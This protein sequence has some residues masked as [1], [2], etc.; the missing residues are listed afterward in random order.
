MTGHIRMGTWLDSL[1][2]HPSD[3]NVWASKNSLVM[4]RKRG[5]SPFSRVAAWVISPYVPREKATHV[6]GHKEKDADGL[7]R[8][9]DELRGHCRLIRY[10]GRILHGSSQSYY[11]RQTFPG[12]R[13]G[14]IDFLLSC[15]SFASLFKGIFD[16]IDIPHNGFPSSSHPLD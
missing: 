4:K 16:A 15:L 9:R 13:E 1:Y 11:I 5:C 10:A 6:G 3:P 2:H 7:G 8:S 14:S 12:E